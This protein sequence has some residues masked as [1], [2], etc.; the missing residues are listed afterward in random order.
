MALSEI[1]FTE[2]LLKGKV[3]DIASEDVLDCLRV[4]SAVSLP[5]G[6]AKELGL[7][8]EDK[9]IKA[10]IEGG[11]SLGLI[12]TVINTELNYM[13]IIYSK[14]TEILKGNWT[15]SRQLAFAEG[16]EV[17]KSDLLQ[18]NFD[19][20]SEYL[21]SLSQIR[22]KKCKGESWR[23]FLS[24]E[25]NELKDALPSI[26]AVIKRHH[27]DVFMTVFGDKFLGVKW[28][29][30]IQLPVDLAAEKYFALFDK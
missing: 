16:V 9:F 20:I 2:Y 21:A 14:D 6:T 7:S 5:Y 11:L 30:L 12:E 29:S 23:R 8:N 27:I 15:P 19:M 22:D 24:Q 3:K 26:E 17:F 1:Q 18:V 4:E 25:L 28:T 13:W 10:S